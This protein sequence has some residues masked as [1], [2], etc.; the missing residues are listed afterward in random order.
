MP[1]IISSMDHS[2]PGTTVSPPNGRAGHAARITNPPTQAARGIPAISL[3]S[4]HSN[5]VELKTY[6]M[7]GAKRIGQGT[8]I[9]TDPNVIRVPMYSTHTNRQNSAP[10]VSHEMP[11]IRSA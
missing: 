5:A 8:G 7:N 9:L 11:E 4:V 1:K 2:E 3:F 6:S 10:M